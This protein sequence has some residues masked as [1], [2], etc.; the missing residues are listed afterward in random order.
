M[1]LSKE[2]LSAII[3]GIAKADDKDKQ[4]L[5]KALKLKTAAEIEIESSSTLADALK[6]AEGFDDLADAGEKAKKVLNEM[7]KAKIDMANIDLEVA[8]ATSDYIAEVEAGAKVY[9]KML[10]VQLEAAEAGED[11]DEALEKLAKQYGISAKEAAAYYIELNTKLTPAFRA[12]EKAGA[13]FAT[14]LGTSMGILSPKANA[15]FKGFMKFSSIAKRPD[16]LMGVAK[17]MSKIINPTTVALGVFALIVTETLKLAFAVDKATAAF[18]KQTGAGRAM[19]EEI[20]AVGGSYRNLGLGAAEAGKAAG[21]LFNSFTGF[22]QMSKGNR[23]DLMLTVASL[24]RIGVSGATAANSLQIMVNNFG[25]STKQ[26]SKMTKQLSIA[27]S[28]IGIS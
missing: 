6:L 15:M 2:E 23:K 11:A 5:A 1:A 19:T 18:A 22:T 16:G 9:E 25:M 17:G 14:K 8:K 28:K 3:D 4:K 20:M 13:S 26:A 21:E 27:G 12:G 24:E 7:K 10:K